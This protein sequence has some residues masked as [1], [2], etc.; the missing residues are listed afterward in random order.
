MLAQLLLLLPSNSL[1]S[2]KSTI[3]SPASKNETLPPGKGGIS[4][5]QKR[6]KIEDC[7]APP[8]SSRRHRQASLGRRSAPGR[9][10]ADCYRAGRRCPAESI[11]AWSRLRRSR[12]IFSASW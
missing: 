7:A 8:L 6:D 11:D 1:S 9:S 10:Y 5:W 4:V 3:D 2:Q 12:A